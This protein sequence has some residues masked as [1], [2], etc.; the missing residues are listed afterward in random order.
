MRCKKAVLQ[1]S[2]YF[3]LK[4]TNTHLKSKQGIII[5]PPSTYGITRFL[6][7]LVKICSVESIEG[8]GLQEVIFS[9]MNETTLIF[10]QVVAHKIQGLYM[11]TRYLRMCGDILVLEG[12][13]IRHPMIIKYE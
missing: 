4:I 12:W 6:S 9:L 1:Q 5:N 2:T 8:C 10:R 3:L 13:C 11:H 7:G